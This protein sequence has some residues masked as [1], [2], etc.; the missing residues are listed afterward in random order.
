MIRYRRKRCAARRLV[1]TRRKNVVYWYAYRSRLPLRAPRGSRWTRTP[2]WTSRTTSPAARTH[3]TSTS[4]PADFNVRTSFRTR[5]SAGYLAYA[6][7][8]MGTAGIEENRAVTFSPQPRRSCERGKREARLR[9]ADPTDRARGA[10][11]HGRRTASSRSSKAGNPNAKTEPP[12]IRRA[13]GAGGHRAR[14]TIGSRKA[15][16]SRGRDS[17]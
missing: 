3:R 10:A 9:G 2:D 14:C 17:A 5:G 1:A 13:E 12:A 7:W 6:T 11:A 15:S 8:Q 4:K 16:S